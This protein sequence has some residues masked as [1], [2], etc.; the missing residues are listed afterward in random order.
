MSEQRVTTVPEWLK[1]HVVRQSAV[2]DVLLVIAASI[3]IAVSA[4]IAIPIWPVPM[5]MQ[6]VA[7]LLVGA[8]L[9]STR[10]ALAAALY[11]LEGLGGLPVFANGAFGPAVFV[12]PTA[13]YL[14]AFP[15]GAWIA[16][17]IS[18]RAWGRSIGLTVLGMALAIATIHLGGW[19]WLST[20]MG[21]GAEK[22][23][24]VG[25]APFWVSDIVKIAIAAT[26]LPAA[27]HLVGSRDRN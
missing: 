27:Q 6:P 25:V 19:S 11:L 18:E 17:R 15:A 26:L 22:A 10:G 3:L 5:T 7:I 8:A 24:L 1:D 13:G 2:R 12:G 20:A 4:Q 16:G 21:L 14:L 23:F 9:G